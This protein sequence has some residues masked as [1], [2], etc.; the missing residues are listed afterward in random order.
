MVITMAKLRIAHAWRTQDP[1]ANILQS[2]GCP[3]KN[4]DLEFLAFCSVVIAWLYDHS[5]D[6]I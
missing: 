2:T 3:R 5:L 6:L 1:W 4:G